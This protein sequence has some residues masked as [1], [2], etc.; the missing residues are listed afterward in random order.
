MGNRI[1]LT[2]TTWEAARSSSRTLSAVNGA[3][4]RSGVKTH[5]MATAAAE[6]SA[7]EMAAA[8]FLPRLTERFTRLQQDTQIQTVGFCEAMALILPVFDHLGEDQVE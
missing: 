5:S 1:E 6:P 7:Q 8:P 3:S 2:A 4:L